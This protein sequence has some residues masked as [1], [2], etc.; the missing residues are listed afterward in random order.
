MNEKIT[1]QEAPTTKSKTNQNSI[2][3]ET[4]SFDDAY[5]A[6]SGGDAA[7]ALEIVDSFSNDILTEEQIA[8]KELFHRRFSPSEEVA[9]SG[10]SKLVNAVMTFYYAYWN[11]VLLKEVP[12]E[13]ALN[14]LVMMVI[15]YLHENYL[16]EQ[17]VG[18]AELQ[19]L[20]NLK[21]QFS[22]LLLQDGYYAN[23]GQTGHVMDIYLWKQE[24]RQSY[25]VDLPETQI[26]IQVV[27]LKDIVTLGW[28]EYAT[29]GKFN[30]G[31]WAVGSDIFC[32]EYQYDIQS[33]H[34]RINLLV[35]EAQHCSDYKTYPRLQQTDWEY[36]AKLA[37][38]SQA[39]ETLCAKITR[40]I[41]NQS[42]QRE[43]AHAFANHCVIRDLSEVVFESGLV[44]DVE[45][46]EEIPTATI[47]AAAVTLLARHSEGLNNAG[48]LEVTQFIK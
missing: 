5:S 45:K 13:Q 12:G 32:P 36:R 16:K 3:A 10:E 43:H 28:T 20:D 14:E 35:H 47:N 26:D 42:L 31:G 1:P 2:I 30:I 41:N 19:N 48:S 27:F 22:A 23:L 7:K 4:H 39:Q 15:P 17:G 46:W 37:E 33:E 21:K 18:I 8:D 44:E 38:L 29:L 34:F 25:T 9:F 11:K 40:F 24:D 6:A